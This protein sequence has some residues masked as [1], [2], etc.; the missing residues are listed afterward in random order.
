MGCH[1]SPWGDTMRK[2]VAEEGYPSDDDNNPQPAVDVFRF[3]LAS[4]G[5]WFDIMPN[6][7]FSEIVEETDDWKSVRN[8]AGAVLKWWKNKSGTPEHIDFRMTTRA[9]WEH[10]Y[11]APLLE[12][13]PE[14]VNTQGAKEN[15]RKRR[16]NGK[17][18]FYGNQ[19]IWENMRC[20]LGDV[21]MFESL[22][23]DPAWIHDYNQV[24]TEF[25]K[26]HYKLLFAEAGLPDGVWVYEDLGYRNGLF[27]SP[28]TMEE[29]IFPYYKDLVDFLH[30]Y[31]LPVVLHACGNITE[32]VPLVVAA[33]F[34]ALNPMEVKAGCNVVEFA[35]Q[36]GDKLAF[37]GGLDARVLESGDRDLIKREVTGLI[38]RLK[39]IGARYVFGS[40]HSLSTEVSYK[41][42]AYAIEV[43]RDHCA[44]D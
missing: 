38:R 5:G 25:F 18:A 11:R 21:C 13:D 8:G 15:L 3:D 7:G 6:R 10:D 31:D 4:V 27:C 30:G 40:D 41:D 2:W 17:W 19:C 37:I 24:Y 14:R 42:Y 29:L 33:G 16:T 35:R 39:D 44:Y 34:D 12:V 26:T 22:V 20:S 36:Y 32:A 28:R 23:L 43:Y 1:D 9:I